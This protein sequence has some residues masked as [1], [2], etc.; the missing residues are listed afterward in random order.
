MD[1][2][3]TLLVNHNHSGGHWASFHL[4]G[5]KSN[6]AAIGT[7]VTV[8]AGKLV[9]MDEVRGG[10]SYLSQSDLRLHF[11]LADQNKMDSVQVNWLSGKVEILQ[12]LPSDRIFTIVEGQGLRN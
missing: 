11:G 12:N 4:V 9:Q 3:P 8:R 7:R 2:P 5:T 6:R 1:A 10:S